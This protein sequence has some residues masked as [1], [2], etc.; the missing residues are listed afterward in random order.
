[1]GDWEI[2]LQCYHYKLV[3]NDQL[4]YRKKTIHSKIEIWL[5]AYQQLV[6][7]IKLLGAQ[8]LNNDSKC[9]ARKRNLIYN[10]QETYLFDT[11]CYFVILRLIF[12]VPWRLNISYWTV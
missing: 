11:R 4:D 12:H 6:K 8:N 9:F 3:T 10:T 5:Q 7:N 1:M 2:I